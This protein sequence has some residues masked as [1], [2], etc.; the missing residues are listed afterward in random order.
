MSQTPT[1]TPRSPAAEAAEREL[2]Q[3][4]VETARAIFDARASSIFLHDT[5]TDELVFQAV[6]GEGEEHLTGTRFPAG[7]G[8][9]GYVLA[10]GEAMVLDDLRGPGPFA[11]DL[12]E[13]TGYVP[14]SLMAAPLAHSEGVIGVLE[15]LDPG[16]R[17]RASLPELEL[18]ALFARQAAAA[19]RL[20]T[21]HRGT[22]AGTATEQVVTDEAVR[23]GRGLELVS[24]LRELLESPGAL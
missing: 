11:R 4:V 17:S 6:S 9:A 7:R 14:A 10:S 13:S 18:L 2:L 16:E 1:R 24:A 23:R 22:R 19:L 8:V 5:E 12:A 21:L 3:S 15:V 20:V